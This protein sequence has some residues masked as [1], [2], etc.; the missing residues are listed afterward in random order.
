MSEKCRFFSSR[1]LDK[2]ES[3][4]QLLMSP[5]EVMKMNLKS[6]LSDLQIITKP[7]VDTIEHKVI[8]FCHLSSDFLGAAGVV[9]YFTSP[10]H[11]ECV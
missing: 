4:Q 8:M 1:N 10:Q 6:L 2:R 9:G 11:S 3:G 7:P 5:S